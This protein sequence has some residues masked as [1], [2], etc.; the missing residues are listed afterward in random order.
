MD[1]RTWSKPVAEGKGDG[2][3]TDVSFNAVKAKFIRIT[4]TGTPD[5]DAH[6]TISSLRLYESPASK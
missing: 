3:R 6:W 5:N 2:T 1:G 4:Q